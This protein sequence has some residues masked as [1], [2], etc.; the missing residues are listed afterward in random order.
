MLFIKIGKKTLLSI[1]LLYRT[2]H[3]KFKTRLCFDDETRLRRY[4]W[5]C[6][7]TASFFLLGILKFRVFYTLIGE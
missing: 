3:A 7:E 5:C 6:G 4:T 2:I 1:L